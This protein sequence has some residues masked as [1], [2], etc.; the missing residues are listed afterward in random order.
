MKSKHPHKKRRPPTKLA[1]SE[2]E[3]GVPRGAAIAESAG[4]R[5]YDS[6]RSTKAD[7]MTP[8]T[9]AEFLD[10]ATDPFISL[11]A[12]AETCGVDP[13]T[14][15]RMIQR[16]KRRRKPLYDELIKVKGADLT[17]MIEDRIWRILQFID[18]GVMADAG[19]KELTVALGTLIDKRQLLSGEPTQIISV[20]ERKDMGDLLGILLREAERRQIPIP[21]VIDLEPVSSVGR[22]K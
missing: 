2:N 14:A 5:Q 9:E 18:E 22:D 10:V 17:A 19:L 16:L 8:A 7:N 4:A 12:A 13:L 15:S 1:R 20:H 11:R 3:H 21:P 6:P